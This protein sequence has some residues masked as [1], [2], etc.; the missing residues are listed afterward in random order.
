MELSELFVSR[1]FSIRGNAV[2]FNIDT[3]RLPNGKTAKREYL[4]H[5]GAVAVVALVD[6]D[7]VVMV[8]Q[9]RHPVREITWEIPAGKLHKNENPLSCVKRELEE[10]TG[11]TTKKNSKLLS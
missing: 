10:E 9:Y 11:Y 6:K 3:V 5:P 2:A 8:K 4:D 7:K 1:N